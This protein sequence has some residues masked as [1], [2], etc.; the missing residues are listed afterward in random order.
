MARTYAAEAIILNKRNFGEADRL[1]TFLSK[2]KGK[3]DGLAKGVRKVASRRGPNLDL[4]NHVNVYLARGKNFDVV[5]E[6]ETIHTFKEAKEDLDKISSGFHLL[7]IT[8]GFLEEGQ[9]ETEIFNL[10]LGSLRRIEAGKDLFKSKET[11]RAFE[12]KFLAEVGFKPQLRQCVVCSREV[13]ENNHLLSP[14]LGGVLDKGCSTNSL[15]SKPISVEAIKLLRFLQK[16]D[17]EKINKLSISPFVFSEL[18]THLKFYIEFLL[19]K[20]LKSVKYLQKI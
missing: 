20:E 14:E 16:E 1:I 6:V 13:N 12:I 11:L 2:Y 3:F 9:G 5:V 18:E 8:N 7:E 4:L 15:L 19:E 17:W 10:L